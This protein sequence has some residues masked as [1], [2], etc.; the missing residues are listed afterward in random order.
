LKSEV[1]CTS[2]RWVSLFKCTRPLGVATH[3]FANAPWYGG[4]VFRLRP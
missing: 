3:C 2:C 1:V 4:R